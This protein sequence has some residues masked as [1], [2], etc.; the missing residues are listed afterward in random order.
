M[1]IANLELY[2]TTEFL[3]DDAAQV[4]RPPKEYYREAR[5][6][7]PD[8]SG[9]EQRT[10]VPPRVDEDDRVSSAP[11]RRGPAYES[12]SET[13]RRIRTQMRNARGH[14]FVRVMVGGSTLF[15][16]GTDIYDPT[17]A[18]SNTLPPGVPGVVAPPPLA[19]FPDQTRADGLFAEPEP[20]TV[21][22]TG[23]KQRVKATFDPG[24]DD[25][26]VVAP[27]TGWLTADPLDTVGPAGDN[28]RTLVATQ[29]VGIDLG[30]DLG[31]TVTGDEPFEYFDPAGKCGD[32]TPHDPVE[33]TFEGDSPADLF[34]EA[35]ALDGPD[36]VLDGPVI[37]SGNLSFDASRQVRTEFTATISGLER[38]IPV[39]SADALSPFVGATAVIGWR[40]TDRKERTRE[41]VFATVT[42][43]TPSINLDEDGLLVSLSGRSGEWF[44]SDAKLTEN[45]EIPDGSNPIGVIKSL[46]TSVA[47]YGVKFAG[48]GGAQ[49]VAEMSWSQGTRYWDVIDD[50]AV[51]AGVAIY[52]DD[53]GVFQI[54]DIPRIDKAGDPVITWKYGDQKLK[55]VRRTLSTEDRVNGAIVRGESLTT[56]A[57]PVEGRAGLS[58]GGPPMPYFHVDRGITDAGTAAA[59][60]ASLYQ[61]N[62]GTPERVDIVA[63]I[64]PGLEVGDTVL[65]RSGAVRLSRRYV[66]RRIAIPLADDDWDMSVSTYER[67]TDLPA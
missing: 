38:Y 12:E 41:H 43:D 1:P 19:Y 65:V 17:K 55:S 20:E 10:G 45:F 14:K 8:T 35:D 34:I 44:Y 51:S 36:P 22:V 27:A 66:A 26:E 30:A 52:V 18:L 15:E 48:G 57:D 28:E 23:S 39:D 7:F 46:V 21:D 4:A 2:A 49:S 5:R 32:V 11:S 6:P 31:E 40:N 9:T 42:L 24:D 67:R 64:E 63:A 33:E 29:P 3:F 61:V 47:P 54:T 53:K 60:A 13:Y 56:D 50:L 58:D 16:T 62:K 37:E 25:A 59:L